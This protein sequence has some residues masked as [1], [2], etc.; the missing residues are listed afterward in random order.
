MQLSWHECYGCVHALCQQI[1]SLLD[2]VAPGSIA[3][4]TRS[5]FAEE[6]SPD[7]REGTEETLD[8]VWQEA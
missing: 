2:Y 8:E 7:C 3:N 4:H 1:R 6:F 5:V